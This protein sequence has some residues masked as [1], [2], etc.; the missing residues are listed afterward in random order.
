MIFEK[1]GPCFA[2]SFCVGWLEEI[3]S[4][5]LKRPTTIRAGLI[6]IGVKGRAVTMDDYADKNAPSSTRNISSDGRGNI[7]L[8]RVFLIVTAS[9]FIIA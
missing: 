5:T 1:R 4:R 7:V 9:P 2:E 8:S 6:Q 3:A